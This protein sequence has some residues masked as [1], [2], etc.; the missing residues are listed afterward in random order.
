[1]CKL[2]KVWFSFLSVFSSIAFSG[3]AHLQYVG[4]VRQR[5]AGVH[6]VGGLDG[7]ANEY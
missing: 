7:S 3:I 2:V 5:E 6:V 1:M 4:A